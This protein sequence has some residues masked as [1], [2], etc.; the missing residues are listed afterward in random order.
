VAAGRLCPRSE[1]SARDVELLRPI[2]AGKTNAKIAATLVISVQMVM[3]HSVSI[4]RKIDARGRAEATAYAYQHGLAA[5]LA[6]RHP[7]RRHRP[8]SGKAGCRRSDPC[9]V[10]GQ[11]TLVGRRRLRAARQ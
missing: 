11:P 1:L 6:P 5:Q 7:P 3:H 2:A 10:T 8:R 9:G 4:Y